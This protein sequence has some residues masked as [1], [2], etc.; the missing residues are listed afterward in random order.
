M[1]TKTQIYT[2][3]LSQSFNL[4]VLTKQVL[5]PQLPPHLSSKV[6]WET[7]KL[8]Q[9]HFKL[10]QQMN[11]RKVWSQQRKK[12]KKRRNQQLDSS[13]LAEQLQLKEEN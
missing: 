5:H 9:Q 11:K 6:Q 13:K 12:L 8:F 3:V 7:C 1:E 4:P 10:Y 2:A